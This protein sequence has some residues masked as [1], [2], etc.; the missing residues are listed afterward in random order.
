MKTTSLKIVLNLIGSVCVVLAIFGVFLPLLPTTP[1]LLLASACFARG[2]E[3]L[4]GWLLRNKTF[5]PLIADFE[6][7]RGIPRRAKVMAL[8]M[9]WLS[10]AWSAS[11]MSS[12]ILVGVLAVVG[13]GVSTYLLFFV[14][15]RPVGKP[16]A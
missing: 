1:F 13:I 7:G 8:T 6:Q 16:D 10:L 3:R 2:S 4:H 11:R 15:T 14:P 12:L 9:L 5:G